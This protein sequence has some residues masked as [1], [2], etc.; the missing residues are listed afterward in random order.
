MSSLKT[1]LISLT[2]ILLMVSST[3]A[4]DGQINS[5]SVITDLT[6]YTT[7][8][9]DHS[10]VLTEE[11]LDDYSILVNLDEVLGNPPFVFSLSGGNADT[12]GALLEQGDESV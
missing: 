2:V 9:S 7:Y 8:E 5:I 1:T 10:F 12:D 3:V 11:E 6:V 4:S